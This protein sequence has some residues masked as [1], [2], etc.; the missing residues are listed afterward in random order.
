MAIGEYLK[1]NHIVAELDVGNNR[2]T[3][4]GATCIAN[5]LQTN[6]TLHVFKVRIANKT[7]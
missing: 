1:Q 6:E 2:I 5:A 7:K 3:T 4:E